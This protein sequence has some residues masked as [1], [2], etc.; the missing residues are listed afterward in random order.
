MSTTESTKTIQRICGMT[1]GDVDGNYGPATA[2]AILATL[3]KCGL[4]DPGAA[5]DIHNVKASSFAD[6]ADVAA[7]RR[8]KAQ[9]NS[10]QVCFRVGDSGVGFTGM[11]CAT[12]DVCICALPPDNWREKWGSKENAA[13]KKVAVT[14]NGKR[15]IGILGDTMPALKNVKNGA[16]I[17][18]NPGFAKA[19]GLTPPFMI[20]VDWEWVTK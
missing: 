13:G 4:S 15:V 18:L 8:C 16:G 6:P 20:N 11:N 19:F 7:F 5:L 14:H 3:G 2:K 10:D 9:G 1:G 12:E 17:D